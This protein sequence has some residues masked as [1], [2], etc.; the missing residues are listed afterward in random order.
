V[1]A[2][3]SRGDPQLLLANVRQVLVRLEETILFALIER[4][5]YA[6]NEVVYRPGAFP[7]LDATESLSGYL[8]RETECIHARMRRYTSPDEHPFFRDLPAPLLPPLAFHENP[9]RPNAVNLNEAVRDA[10][11]HAIVPLLCAAG[12]DGQYG[13]TA[14]CDVACLQSLS[15]R[16][17]YGK[18]VA[19][20]KRVQ[21]GGRVEDLIRAGDADALMK[22]ITLPAVEQEVL[23]RVGRKAATY[24]SELRRHGGSAVPDPERIV[25][26]YRDWII[27]LNK[28]VQVAYLLGT[29]GQGRRGAG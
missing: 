24:V 2:T 19:E 5:Q 13:S 29:A 11:E 1:A 16:I 7:A 15:R 10:Y 3:A 6:R 20:S 25:A 23:D 26:V 22:A 14:V 27:P 21:D 4:A 17:H 8:L 9:L 12:D 28:R 18:F